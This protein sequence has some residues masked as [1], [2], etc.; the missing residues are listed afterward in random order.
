MMLLNEAPAISFDWLDMIAQSAYQR[1][2]S[3]FYQAAVESQCPVALWREPHQAGQL[4]LVDFSGEARRAKIDFTQ[5]TPGFAF[6]PFINPGGRETRF[7][8]AGLVLKPTGHRRFPENLSLQPGRANRNRDRFMAAYRQ[9]ITGQRPLKRQWVASH[10]QPRLCPEADYCRLV[11]TAIDYIKATGIKKVVTSRATET[12]L[13]HDFDPL[14]TFNELSR[15]YAHAF[16]SLVSLPDAGTWIGASPEVLLRLADSELYTVA[17]AG[18]QPRPS[19][20]PLS[21]VSWG[22]KEIEEQALVSDYIR[23]FFQQRGISQ[24]SEEG[25]FTVSAGQIVHRQ[26]QFR[27]RLAEPQLSHLANQILDTLHPTSAV[28]GMPKPEALAFILEHENYD[29]AFYSGFLGPLHLDQRSDLF[30]N[31]RCMQLKPDSAILYV[32]GGIT[33]DSLPQ[34]EWTETVLKSNTLLNVLRRNDHEPNHHNPK[35]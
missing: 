12:P 2:L 29:R 14:A 7:L 34:A 25:P 21:A 5:P 11:A 35:I 4:A 32:G 20:R 28:C 9:L 10:S 24:V 22:A 26:T 23:H 13:P 17:L 6:A 18:T 31:L 15:R 1:T 27:V 33:K 19:D 30:V 8:Q 3:A 16:I